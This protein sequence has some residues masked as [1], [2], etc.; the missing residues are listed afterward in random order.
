MAKA[1]KAGDLYLASNVDVVRG[2]KDA[3]DGD[4]KMIKVANTV[5]IAAGQMVSDT[6]LKPEEI[7]HLKRQGVL[8]YPTPAEQEAMDA[9]EERKEAMDA[10]EEQAE[11]ATDLAAEQTLER[12]RLEAEQA[13]AAAE[14]QQKLAAKQEKERAATT[15][16]KK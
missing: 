11:K 5:T 13:K 8:R 9:A 2:T 1:R 16:K 4:G 15:E 7:K 12:Q 6:D 10:A 14:E 3:K